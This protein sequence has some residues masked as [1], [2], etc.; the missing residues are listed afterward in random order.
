MTTSKAPHSLLLFSAVL[1]MARPTEACSCGYLIVTEADVTPA[2]VDVAPLNAHV[3][4][5]FWGAE[6]PLVIWSDDSHVPRWAPA[7]Q[8]PSWRLVHPD[9]IAVSL[10]PAAPAGGQPGGPV[11]V[12]TTRMATT[13]TRVVEMIPDAALGP[14]TTYEVVATHQGSSIVVSRFNTGDAYDTAPP[15]LSDVTNAVPLKKQKGVIT[16]DPCSSGEYYADL[17]V[18]AVADDQTR[19]ESVRFAVWTASGKEPIDLAAPPVTYVTRVAGGGLLLGHWTECAWNLDIPSKTRTLQVAL[20]AVDL[21][22]NMSPPVQ[23]TARLTFSPW[24]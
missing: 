2:P 15:S 21:A 9:Q 3:R 20:R 1:L 18:R 24:D 4:V 5:T 22:G 17:K 8:L 23:L 12:R 14:G 6:E 7:E 10:R 19:T 16:L 11:S 13:A